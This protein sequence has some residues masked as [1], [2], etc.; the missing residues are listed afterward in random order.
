MKNSTKRILENCKSDFASNE[1]SGPLIV[2]AE[3]LIE[4]SEE[5][6]NITNKIYE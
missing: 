2:I 6:K 1:I 3:V 5:L 4:I